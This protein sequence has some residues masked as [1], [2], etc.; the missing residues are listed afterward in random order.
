[1]G[2]CV[3]VAT[4]GKSGQMLINKTLI[5]WWRKEKKYWGM[6]NDEGFG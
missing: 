6:Q 4:R 5:M 3:I 2:G 1:V